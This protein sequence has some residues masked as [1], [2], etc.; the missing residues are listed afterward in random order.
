V[1]FNK[2]DVARF[3]NEA[4][5][6][7]FRQPVFIEV[8]PDAAAKIIRL[9]DVK[10]LSFRVFIEVNAWLGGKLRYYFPQSRR[11]IGI[12]SYTSIVTR[13]LCLAFL[14]GLVASPVVF[15]QAKTQQKPNNPPDETLPPEEDESVAPKVYPLNPLESDR[16][17]K[18]GN[19]YM[20]KGTAQGYRAA[21][22]R[23]EEATKYNPSSPEAF[24]KIGEAH[25]K[26]KN[27]DA[28]KAAFQKVIQ[29]APDSKFAHEAKKKLS[30][31]TQGS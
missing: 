14:I 28:A 31:K 15:S 29:L 17:V 25:E 21:L 11:L 4:S 22:S 20:H 6:L 24:F 30:A 13:T 1:D 3:P 7:R 23:Y 19:F 9:T 5:G 2:V 8:A 26:L 18:V 10:N 12:D 16:C 27:N